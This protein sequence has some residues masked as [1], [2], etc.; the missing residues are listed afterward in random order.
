MLLRIRLFLQI[1]RALWR[2]DLL[3]LRPSVP[4]AFLRAWWHCGN[5][6]ACLAEFAAHRFPHRCAV[7]DEQGSLTFAELHANAEI[8]AA[9]LLSRYALQSGQRVA[10]LGRNQRGLLIALI[11]LGRLGVDVLLLGTE[12]PS[13]ALQRILA[14]QAPQLILHDA[15]FTA[16]LVA[17]SSP[18]QA[19]DIVPA[20]QHYRLPRVRRAGRIVL[21]TSGTTGAAKSIARRPTLAGVLPVLA[22]LLRALPLRLHAPALC[23]IPLYHGYGLATL[24]MALTFGAP[25]HLARKCEIAPLLARLPEDTPPVVVISIPTLLARW[26]S[27]LDRAPMPP[28]AAVISGSAP[29]S[30]G[31][32]QRL[33]DRIGPRLFNLYGSTEAGIIALATPEILLEAPGTVGQPLLGNRVRI[34]PQTSEIQVQGP[35]VLAAPKSGWYATGD[36]GH[37]DQQGRLFVCG[38]SDSMLISGG[39]N[40][41]PQETETTLLEHPDLADAAV[42]VVD[43]PEFGQALRAWVVLKPGT[44]LDE[45]A[46][47]EW[48]RQRLERFKLPRQIA[49]AANIPRNALGKVDQQALRTLDAP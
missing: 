22:G 40:V 13:S 8:L 30:P 23:A 7:V 10:L 9:D 11:S 3:S 18:C 16:S 19:I 26:L 33:Q 32:C 47:R 6:Y 29:L 15:E 43:D 36:L 1:L 38:R 25:L 21:L 20:K 46:L 44:T 34:A 14:V 5:S 31:L 4:L 35:L 48:L 17:C 39:E 27:T 49:L 12:I 37:L 28:L 42:T 24:A 2:I 45:K 41:Y